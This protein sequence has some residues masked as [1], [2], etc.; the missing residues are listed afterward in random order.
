ML[1]YLVSKVGSVAG[2]LIADLAILL[3]PGLLIIHGLAIG[4]L[5]SWLTLL[6]VLRIC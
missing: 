5:S 1:G 2:G 6:W 3:I 4:G